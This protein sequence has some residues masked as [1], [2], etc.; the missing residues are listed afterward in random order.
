[1]GDERI[2]SKLWSPSVGRAGY[3]R[4]A[5][6]DDVPGDIGAAGGVHRQDELL[7]SS[8]LANPWVGDRP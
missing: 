3:F 8:L 1:M 4:F 6:K 7:P 2:R 5:Q